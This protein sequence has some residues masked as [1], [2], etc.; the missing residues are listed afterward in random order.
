VNQLL[1]F[2]HTNVSGLNVL[3]PT[4]RYRL[5]P[6][7]ETSK[8]FANQRFASYPTLSNITRSEKFYEHVLNDILEMEGGR[9]FQSL[10]VDGKKQSLHRLMRELQISTQF[11]G[12]DLL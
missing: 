2:P 6:E 8:R 4:Q 12:D 9:E 3:P 7:V 1:F 5:S 11:L 10:E